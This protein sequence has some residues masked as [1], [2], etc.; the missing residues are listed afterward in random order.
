MKD[1]EQAGVLFQEYGAA[2]KGKRQLRWSP[3]LRNYLG[4]GAEATDEELAQAQDED[5]GNFAQL[6]RRQLGRIIWKGKRGEVLEVA[7]TQ[8]IKAFQVYLQSLGVGS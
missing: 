4:L 7:S 6:T 2:M 5:G 8:E 1:D 3:G